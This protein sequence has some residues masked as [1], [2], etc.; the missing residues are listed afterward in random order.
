MSQN[1]AKDQLNTSPKLTLKVQEYLASTNTMEQKK[2]LAQIQEELQKKNS[3]LL[4]FIQSL[5]EALVNQDEVRRAKG[6]LF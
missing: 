1:D 4:Q 3:T 2:I 6:C 5:G